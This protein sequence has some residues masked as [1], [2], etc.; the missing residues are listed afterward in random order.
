MALTKD[1]KIKELEQAI[2]E[3][4]HAHDIEL[5]RRHAE[6]TVLEGMLAVK[7]K[8]IAMWKERG[9][10][11]SAAHA[12]IE[13]EHRAFLKMLADLVSSVGE[14]AILQKI[15]DKLPLREKC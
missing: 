7:D 11:L 12:G 8:E 13:T 6:K 1:G 4:D 10:R 5:I 15:A 14:K 9:D 3:R 2:K